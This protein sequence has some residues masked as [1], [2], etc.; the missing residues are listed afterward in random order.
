MPHYLREHPL[1]F[2]PLLLVFGVIG[3][4]LPIGTGGLVVCT[5]SVLLGLGG[6]GLGIYDAIS[7]KLH[8]AKIE[9][10]RRQKSPLP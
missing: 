3:L 2:G 8:W 10:E 6:I 4:V 5:G 9:R 1:L 7:W